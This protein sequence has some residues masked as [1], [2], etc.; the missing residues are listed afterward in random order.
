MVT[1]KRQCHT[2]FKKDKKNDLRNY[3]PFSLTSVLG[4][5]MEKILLEGR[6][7]IHENQ[8]GC[9]NG[10]YCLTN[11]VVFSDGVTESMDKER[12]TDVIYLNFSKA[13]DKVPHKVLL[14]NLERYAF[15]LFSG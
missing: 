2:H 9:T 15:V 5:I 1:G 13:F 8:H 10:K 3:Q 14:S 6:E 11:L 12:A 4:E 7:V